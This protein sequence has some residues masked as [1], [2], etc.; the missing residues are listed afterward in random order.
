MGSSVTEPVAVSPQLSMPLSSQ[1]ELERP[2]SV[3]EYCYAA[4]GSSADTLDVPREIVYVFE[5]DSTLERADWQRALDAAV[6]VHPGVRLRITG[7]RLG[8]RWRSDGPPPRLR[9][10]CDCDWD[11]RGKDGS[12]FITAAPLSV[13]SGPVAELIVA[14]G[15][16]LT[17]LI[18]RVLHAVMD[19][20]GCQ[21]FMQD[22][23]RAL[24]GEP[25]QGINCSDSDTALFKRLMAPLR[26][27]RPQ[28]QA[29]RRA[30]PLTGPPSGDESGDTWRR[31]SLHGPQ[32]QLTA[33]LV[34]ALADFAGRDGRVPLLFRIAIDLRRHAPDLRLTSMFTST[35]TLP[36][37]PGERA[38]DFAR[39]LDAQLAGG[40][41]LLQWRRE[42]L[43]L[44]ESIRLLSFGALDRLIA[45][46]PRNFRKRPSLCTAIVSNHG[47]Q[48]ASR[49]QC[50]GFRLRSLFVLGEQEAA[51]CSAVGVGER[52]E[53]V[54]G[55]PRIQASDGRLD[56]LM[57]H[58]A[59]RLG[60]D[61]DSV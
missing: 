12:A 39:R 53:L 18:F 55:M 7:Q 17:R 14:E 52:C 43:W 34:E 46:T 45:R 37:Q 1:R 3:S 31:L 56:A 22:L 28:P 47:R 41:H 60:A 57:R 5:A 42:A 27:H 16:G 15:S 4:L 8:A 13:R 20:R 50:P 26:G 44:A 54:V 36:L 59:E 30:K 21:L 48:D 35:L 19:G 61:V 49:Y 11:G 6:Q 10:V 25:L 29:P 32:P 9:Q 24:R 38:T 33:R 23:F 2:L 51:R 58:L 40:L